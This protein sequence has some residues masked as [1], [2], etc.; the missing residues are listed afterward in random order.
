MAD[1][2]TSHGFGRLLVAV[3]AVFALSASARSLY[4]LATH[5]AD[6]PFAYSLSALAALVYLVATYALATNRQRLASWTIGFELVGV[7]AVGLLTLLDPALFPDA[8][9]WSLFGIQY[10]FV[11][12]VLPLVGLWWVYRRRA[13]GRA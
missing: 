8:T 1:T 6:A 10:A 7:L 2:H 11:P 5:A 4:Q 3:Y 9:V 13:A 12:L